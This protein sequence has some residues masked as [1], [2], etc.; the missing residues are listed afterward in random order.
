MSQSTV[1][2]AD[3][4]P[5]RSCLLVNRRREAVEEKERLARARYS[6]RIH[7]PHSGSLRSGHSLL[8][9][10]PSRWAHNPAVSSDCENDAVYVPT[11]EANSSG[12][13]CANAAFLYAP[14]AIIC[15]HGGPEPSK[16]ERQASTNIS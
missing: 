15:G 9:S 4:I 13:M 3:L 5:L 8:N 12:P 7:G 6:S 10:Q 16:S 2:R 14:A 11:D 1:T